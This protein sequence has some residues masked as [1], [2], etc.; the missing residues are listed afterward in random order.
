LVTVRADP[1][2]VA[3]RG[4]S[5][6]RP[7]NTLVAFECA[8]A[9]GAKCIEFDVQATADGALVVHHDY[10][11]DRTTSG[12]GLVFERTVS[13]VRSL[14]AGSWFGAAFEEERVPLLDEVLA[15]SDLEFELE[16]KGFGPRLLADVLA[17][18]RAFD[19]FA[20]T[21]FSS[22]NIPMLLA[23]KNRCPEAR[24]GLFSRRRESWM[25][26]QVFERTVTS[27][28]P[29]GAFDV[30]HVYAADVT[31]SLVDRIHEC[32]LVA[33]AND[34]VDSAEIHSAVEAGVDRVSTN[35]VELAVG[36]LSGD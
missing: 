16:I 33:H 8:K 24:L 28:V 31:S 9:M 13:Y 2:V 5:A 20:R 36:V 12:N 3:H 7:E 30:V 35:D 18:V 17:A 21:E 19:A 32:G 34:A 14:D 10:L 4:A 15:I 27:A 23:L 11:L 1:I 25:L 6:V 26:D 29:F 22:W